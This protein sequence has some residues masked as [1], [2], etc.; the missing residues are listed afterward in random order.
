M[1]LELSQD[2]PH[3]YLALQHLAYI[4]DHLYGRVPF[5]YRE[6]E[7]AVW[8]VNMLLAMGYTWEDIQIQE[9]SEVFDETVWI[10]RYGLQQRGYSQNVILTVPGQ[11]DR[12]IVVGAHYDSFPYPGA[13]DNASGM[14]LL[15]ESAQRMRQM[16][17]YHTIVYIFFGS[18]EVQILGAENYVDE[19][20]AADLDDIL[21]M[22]S[23][24]SLFLGPYFLYSTGFT[25]N[26]RSDMNAI[27]AAWDDI[28]STIYSLHEI[29]LI[30]YPD[31]A[32][33]I[34]SDHLRFYSADIPVVVFIGLDRS[35]YD[36]SPWGFGE[37]IIHHSPLDCLHYFNEIWPGRVDRA[38]MGYSLFLE[39]ILLRQYCNTGNQFSERSTSP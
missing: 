16:D 31:G 19:L 9:F 26:A 1:P 6:K 20:S 7:A 4:N 8:L 22:V 27:T 2:T 14:A 13:A 11:G 18:E 15:L 29:E 24:D 12:V 25:E 10:Y 34:G 5:T 36:D 30:A 23:A 28:A 32:K 33:W 21:F 17:N 39:G 37:R 35:I 38:L 3:G